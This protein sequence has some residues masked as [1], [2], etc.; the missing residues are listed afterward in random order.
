MPLLWTCQCESAFKE[1][2]QRLT[3]QP[4]LAFPKL[5]EPFTVEVDASDYAA[6]GVLSQCGDDGRDAR[7]PIDILLGHDR[8][9]YPRDMNTA[10]EYAEDRNFAL[11]DVYDAIISNLNLSKEKMQIQYNKNLRFV[12][13]RA[14]YNVW[15]KVK[16]YKTGENRKL[17]HC[18]RGPWTVVKKLPNGVNFEICNDQTK[19]KKIVHHD[20]L[21]PVRESSI[22]E[23]E[24]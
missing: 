20:R 14:G 7:S 9:N 6:G 16:Y 11:K 15:L 13:H 12:D 8:F 1:L 5:N 10:A 24:A 19:E 23:G 4:V 17:A 21:S 2:K 3:S 22:E 18:R